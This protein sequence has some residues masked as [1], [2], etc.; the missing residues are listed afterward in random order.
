MINPNADADVS[1]DACLSLLEW[2]DYLLE[3]HAGIDKND[4]SKLDS[5]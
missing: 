1:Q 3:P 5:D 4:D 2:A